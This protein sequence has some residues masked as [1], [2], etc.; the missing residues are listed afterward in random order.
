MA[1]RVP[2]GRLPQLVDAATRVFVAQGYRRTQIADVAQA[3]DV[4]KG[5][6]YLY[7]ESKEALFDLVLRHAD[8]PEAAK[9]LELPVQAPSPGATLRYVR[10]ELER[11]GHLPELERA[12]ARRRVTDVARELEGIVRELLQAL[13][14]NRRR[15][16]VLDSCHR[17]YPALAAVWLAFAHRIHSL[18]EQYLRERIERGGLRAVPDFGA[19]ARL[20][21]ETAVFW[22]IHRHWDIEPQEISEATAHDTVVRFVVAALVREKSA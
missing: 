16:K 19:A 20:I 17:D 1:R 3:I 15:I 18:L 12:L 8:D 22:A 6:L 9:D 10:N 11:R 13:G 5:T 7:V 2:D 21:L 14:R 4:A